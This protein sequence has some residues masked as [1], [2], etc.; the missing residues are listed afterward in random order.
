MSRN[1]E[2]EEQYLK[3]ELTLYLKAQ[4]QFLQDKLDNTPYPNHIEW[5]KDFSKKFVRDEMVTKLR[6]L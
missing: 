6:S 1:R 2:L 5:E 3:E 4:I